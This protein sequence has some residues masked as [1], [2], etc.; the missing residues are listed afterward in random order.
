M[1]WFE[2]HLPTDG[3]VAVE[4]LGL[5][6][7]GLA[8]PGRRAREVLAEVTRAD[9]SNAAF[10][11]MAIAAHGYRHGAVPGR[12]RQLHGRPRLRDLDGAGVPAP[13]LRGLDGC[14][15]AEF[16]IGLFGG[17]ALNA[18]RLEKNYG[19]WAREYRPIYG[20][21]GGRAR[22]L[23]RLWQ[24]GRLHRQGSGAGRAGGGRQAQAAR[25]HGGGRGRRRHRRRAD[26]ARGRSARL[27]DV[28]RLRPRC[29]ARVEGDGRRMAVRLR[30]LD[31]GVRRRHR[32]VA[33]KLG[34]RV[35]LVKDACGSGSIAMHQTGIL[36][37]ANRLYG[38]A[39]TDTAGACR[40]MAGRTDRVPGSPTR[41]CRYVSVSRMRVSSMLRFE[42]P[43][44][45]A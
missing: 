43:S 1:R 5:R 19:S 21:A 18:L 35:V 38:G 7:C 34:F 42:A 6:L 3:S 39:I 31:G 28:R 15:R 2:T 30:R 24:G 20:P 8:S 36:N 9:V 44:A 33:L 41:R 12:P 27:G 14:R 10:P 22:P 23:R 16:G 45:A 17:R 40:L 11:F 29:W 25:L 37:L 4:A 26:L 13:C 32:E